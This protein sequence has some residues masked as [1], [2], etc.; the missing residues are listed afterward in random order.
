MT[1]SGPHDAIP[2][3]APHERTFTDTA[4]LAYMLHRQSPRPNAEGA[5]VFDAG[6]ALIPELGDENVFL[7]EIG[8]G[9]LHFGGSAVACLPLVLD[10]P[11]GDKHMADLLS[12]FFYVQV[13][14]PAR[15]S[16]N[17]QTQS[18]RATVAP[19][20][21]HPT[22]LPQ[23]LAQMLRFPVYLGTTFPAT[24]PHW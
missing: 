3:P 14:C 8:F 23:S 6:F 16:G 24:A 21:T 20:P 12:R 9:W 19:P 4:K 10:L 1:T 18:A 22:I 2:P 15:C 13:S 7:S 5:A 11:I 17:F